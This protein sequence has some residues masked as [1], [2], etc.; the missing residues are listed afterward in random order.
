MKQLIM[1]ERE[2][3][4]YKM[5]HKKWFERTFQVRLSKFYDNLFYGFDV[6]AFDTFLMEKDAEYAKADGVS[7]YDHILK[8]YGRVA[9]YR[10][11]KFIGITE[12][13]Q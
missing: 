12:D 6:V 11:R 3:H 2:N 13:G 9:A 1:D 8:K 7:T 4:M 5:K 10:I